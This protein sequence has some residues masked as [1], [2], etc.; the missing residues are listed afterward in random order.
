MLAGAAAALSPQNGGTLVLSGVVVRRQ[1]AATKMTH[2]VVFGV[3]E[4]VPSSPK[5]QNCNDTSL[6]SASAR[7]DRL[8]TGTRTPGS[9]ARAL[10]T[11]FSVLPLPSAA[12][13]RGVAQCAC[14]SGLARVPNRFAGS[15]V[16]SNHS[17]SVS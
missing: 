13:G 16:I 9:P 17:R 11:D 3:S 5:G 12:G 2:Q 10:L 1:K 15:G 6:L 4:R 14:G 7:Q 8:K